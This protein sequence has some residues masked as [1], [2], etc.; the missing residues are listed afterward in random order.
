MAFGSILILLAFSAFCEGYIFIARCAVSLYTG[1]HCTVSHCTNSLRTVL[2]CTLSHCT[3]LLYTVKL[4]SVLLCTVLI[5]PV[6]LCNVYL[7]TVLY[8]VNRFTFYHL[9]LYSLTLYVSHSNIS[10]CTVSRSDCLLFLNVNLH[11]FYRYQVHKG[12][13]IKTRLCSLLSYVYQFWCFFHL[14]F[15]TIFSISVFLDIL[16]TYAGVVI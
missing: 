9:T 15:F 3:V 6:P 7:C 5:C 13:H 8:I 12:N 11:F 4:Y 1:S 10:L 2:H 14:Y 16:K